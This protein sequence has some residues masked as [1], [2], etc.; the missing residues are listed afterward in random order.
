MNDLN[1][2]KFSLRNAFAGVKT[3]FKTQRNLRYHGLVCIL[4]LIVG[5][6]L[7]LSAL[8]F[9][10][11]I[12]TVLTVIIS[13]MFNTAVEFVVDLISPEY[14][15]QAKKAK[16]VSAAAVLT[17]AFFSV[18]IGLILFIPRIVSLL[19]VIF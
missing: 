11:L 14:N 2:F 4:V 15:V 5:W 17:S 8:E 12:L 6:L 16:D 3:A 18:I 10:V 1:R 13:E 7:Q 9:L 19:K